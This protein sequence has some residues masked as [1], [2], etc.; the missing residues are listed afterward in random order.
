VVKKVDSVVIPTCTISLVY[1][2]WKATEE[3]ADGL[4][5]VKVSD[6]F[7]VLDL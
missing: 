5:V 6:D 4:L 1:L 7:L 3:K 2:L